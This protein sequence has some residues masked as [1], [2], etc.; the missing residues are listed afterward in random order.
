MQQRTCQVFLKNNERWENTKIEQAILNSG[1][2][3]RLVQ[4]TTERPPAQHG[5]YEVFH[6]YD[7]QGYIIIIR[8][9]QINLQ[10]DGKI[11][12]TTTSSFH[13]NPDG[14]FYSCRFP[15]NFEFKLISPPACLLTA[16]MVEKEEQEKLLSI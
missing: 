3:V 5:D 8:V 1:D 16:L 11:V 12:W 9:K 2:H 14:W 13:C 7:D 4:Y 15:K 10:P 6:R